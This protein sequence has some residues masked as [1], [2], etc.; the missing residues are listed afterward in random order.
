VQEGVKE[1]ESECTAKDGDDGDDNCDCCDWSYAADN[2]DWHCHRLTF[3]ANLR[4]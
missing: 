3:N 4:F 2:G 1:Q